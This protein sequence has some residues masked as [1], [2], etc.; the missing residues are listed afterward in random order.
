MGPQIILLSL[1]SFWETYF[2][3]W[4]PPDHFTVITVIL[5]N[6]FELLWDHRSFYCHYSHFKKLIQANM[7]PHTILLSLLSFWETLVKFLE[8]TVMTV[9]WSRGSYYL[10]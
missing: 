6:F 8:M 3:H 9:K 2:G 7:G 4:Q 10:K 5:V 1:L